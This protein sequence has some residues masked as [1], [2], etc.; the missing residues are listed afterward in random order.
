M[1][2]LSL[3]GADCSFG[4][5]GLYG[6]GL[7]LLFECTNIADALLAMRHLK[8]YKHLANLSLSASLFAVPWLMSCFV[9]RC[10][11]CVDVLW[12][13]RRLHRCLLRCRCLLLQSAARLHGSGRR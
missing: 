2:T 4:F 3:S 5:A 7:P 11:A 8:L 13:D 6:P 12:T 9:S 10:V 1:V